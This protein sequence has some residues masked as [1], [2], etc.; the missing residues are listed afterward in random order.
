MFIYKRANGE[1][2]LIEYID[3]EDEYEI[4]ECIIKTIRA[5]RTNESKKI[6]SFDVKFTG[7]YTVY[8]FGGSFVILTTNYLLNK[9]SSIKDTN[10]DLKKI[11]PIKKRRNRKK[12]NQLE[13]NKV[14]ADNKTE[15]HSEAK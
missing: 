15:E 14:Q 11:L 7:I 9:D 3:S 4:E 12:K 5:M 10:P 8:D 6:Y 13:A 1:C 2:K